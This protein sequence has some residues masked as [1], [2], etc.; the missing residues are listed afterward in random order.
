MF[1][2][3]SHFYGMRDTHVLSMPIR[4]FWLMSSMVDRIQAQE[5]IRAARISRFANADQDS[6]QSTMNDLRQEVGTV[7]VSWDKPDFEGIERLK[8][9]ANKLSAQ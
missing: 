4:R 8:L 2:R 6:A 3:V 1:C 7:I 9:I 5:D